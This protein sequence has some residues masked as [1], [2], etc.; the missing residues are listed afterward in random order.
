MEIKNFMKNKFHWLIFIVV[1]LVIILLINATRKIGPAKIGG[2][3]IPDGAGQNGPEIPDGGFAQ[4]EGENKSQNIEGKRDDLNFVWSRGKCQGQGT[5]QFGTLPMKP[6]DFSAYLPY[7]A[8]ADA[9]ITPI[10]HSYFSPTVFNSPRDAYEVR[11][12]ADGTIVQIGTRNIVVGDQNHNQAKAVEYRLDIEHTC[13][14]YSYFDLIT[15][16]APDIKAEF[17]K[18][19]TAGFFSGRIPVKEGQLI[20][21]IGGQTLDFGVY[22]NDVRLSGFINPKSYWGEPWKIHTDDPFKYFKEP[23]R[24]T[25]LSKN[26]RTAEPRAGKIDYDIAGKAIGNW[27]AEGTNGYEG[28]GRDRYWDGHL[29]LIPDYLDPSQIRFSIGNFGGVAKQ[30]GV[31]GNGPNPATIDVSTGLVKYELVQFSYIDNDT[32]QGWMMTKNVANVSASNSDF[33]QGVA[34]VQMLE[35]GKLK[36]EVFPGKKA[37]QVSAFTNKARIYVR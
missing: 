28:L 2:P 6:E 9:H 18:Q 24:S 27:F 31:K 30:F 12:I 20:G 35:E 33:V 15:S 36:V 17:D 4:K 5:V 29:A 34:L 8:L 13:T 23:A 37:N 21:R 25:L 26:P 19:S 11:A 7:G 14:L 3:T 32:K 16:L 1:I 22:N 10:D